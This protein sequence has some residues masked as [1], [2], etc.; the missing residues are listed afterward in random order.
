M[1]RQGDRQGWERAQWAVAVGSWR[2]RKQLVRLWMAELGVEVHRWVR[3][4]TAGLGIPEGAHGPAGLDGFLAGGPDGGWE[5]SSP[6]T[7]L[8]LLIH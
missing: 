1:L 7:A 5:T 8:P 6:C 3:P 2:V 4:G